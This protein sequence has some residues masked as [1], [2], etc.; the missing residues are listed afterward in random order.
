[1]LCSA[2]VWVCYSTK[3][4]EKLSF[5]SLSTQSR[6]RTGTGVNLLVFETSASTDSAIW[7]SDFSELRCKYTTYFRNC[8]FFMRF[9]AQFLVI[10]AFMVA[11][12]LARVLDKTDDVCADNHLD[13]ATATADNLD[14]VTLELVFCT[15]AHIACKHNLDT[16]LLHIGCDA[17]FATATLG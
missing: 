12:T 2:A 6:G 13:I 5:L 4:R 15:L 7:A 8:K 14:V 1:M 17:R 3:K 11:T 10:V 16:H 9:F